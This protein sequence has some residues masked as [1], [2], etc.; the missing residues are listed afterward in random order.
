MMLT[1]YAQGAHATPPHGVY[2]HIVALKHNFVNIFGEILFI[3]LHLVLISI[4]TFIPKMTDNQLIGHLIYYF[5]FSKKRLA[6]S[7][8]RTVRA[9][10]RIIKSSFP[11]RGVLL[12]IVPPK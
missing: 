9:I 1:Y 2:Y 5:N 6:T 11:L 12:N 10:R 3:L 8:I 7:K 4:L